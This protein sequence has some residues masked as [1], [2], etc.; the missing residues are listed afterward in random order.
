M[1]GFIGLFLN[2]SKANFPEMLIY[3]TQ[4]IPWRLDPAV[5]VKLDLFESILLGNSGCGTYYIPSSF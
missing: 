3:Q 1:K 5:A 2:Q 4:Y